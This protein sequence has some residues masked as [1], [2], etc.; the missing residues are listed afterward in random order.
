MK[1]L[2]LICLFLFA[3]IQNI[4]SQSLT[5][6][7]LIKVRGMDA[8]GAQTYLST[9]GWKFSNASE[10]IGNEF[11]LSSWSFGQEA[12]SDRAKAF[13]R[14]YTKE[15][16]LSKVVYQTSN[17]ANYEVIRNKVLSY[18]MK[19]ETSKIEN[20]YITTSYIGA[21]YFVD[22]TISTDNL[23]NTPVYHVS[24]TKKPM[25]RVF[26][27]NDFDLNDNSSTT[28]EV[29]ELSPEKI[30]YYK[31]MIGKWIS[32]PP[33]QDILFSDTNSNNCSL[34]SNTEDPNSKIK[35]I[36]PNS[37][38]SVLSQLLEEDH[39]YY[40]VYVNNS[41]GYIHVDNLKYGEPH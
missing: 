8:D 25:Y 23:S 12:Y 5:L 33:T 7:E 17:R 18:K 21:N 28:K 40:L 38:I 11:D 16:Y 19:K 3:I 9:K 35:T 34:I 1:R 26:E 31:K 20:G 30:A 24:I 6:D 32:M 2:F 15:G 29:E 27:V 13:V 10:G 14:L 36:L 37:K 4:K 41:L 39:S 22:L